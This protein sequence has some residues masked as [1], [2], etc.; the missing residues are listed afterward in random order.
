MLV[1]SCFLITVIKYLKGHWSPGSLY[2]V[3]KQKVGEWVSEWQGHLLSCQV[4]AKNK[5]K[6]GFL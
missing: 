3:E 2:N 4:T 6:D 1:R 5:K